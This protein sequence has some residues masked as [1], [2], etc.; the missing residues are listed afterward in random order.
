MTEEQLQERLAHWQRVLKL[1]DWTVFV[2]IARDHEM[3]EESNAGEIDVKLAQRIAKIWLRDPIDYTGRQWVPIDLERVLVHE[4]LHI[5][6]EALWPKK[7][8]ASC[9]VA[10]EQAINAIADALIL[11]DRKGLDGNSG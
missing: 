2:V 5:H 3:D 4:M 8:D 11:L 6:F 1:Q 9:H 10:E 7:R